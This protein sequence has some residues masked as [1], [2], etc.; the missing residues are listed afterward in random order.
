MNWDL[1][2]KAKMEHKQRIVAHEAQQ[3][4]ERRQQ[5]LRDAKN[6]STRQKYLDKLEAE[7]DEKRKLA[8]IAIDAE[9]EPRKLFL[10]REWLVNN[11][12]KTPADFE[13][14]AWPLLRQNLLAE[15]EELAR[16]ATIAEGRASG[17]YAL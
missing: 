3:A 17:R 13:R 8:D 12:G 4:E 16:Q 10:Q 14:V 7:K 9:L 6:A 2:N 15:R 1:S 11:A 5:S